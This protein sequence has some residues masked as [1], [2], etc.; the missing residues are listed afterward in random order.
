MEPIEIIRIS[1]ISMIALVNIYFI[2]AHFKQVHQDI[3]RCE[4]VIKA[5]SLTFYKAF[6]KIKDRKKRHAV[7]AVYAFCRYA[8]D[9]ID[10]ANDE[11]GLLQL[12]EDLD[13][14]VK[15]HKAPNYIFRALNHTTK[16]FYAKDYDYNPFYDMIKGQLMDYRFIGYDT[17]EQLLDY[18]YH[19]ASTVGL[20]LV[21][22]LSK[23]HSEQ[24]T[25]F[26]INLGYGMQITN[27]LRD[28]GEDAKKGRIYIPKQEISRANYTIHDLSH[29]KINVEFINMF[30]ALA[31]KAEA[32]FEQAL[33]DINLFPKDV[34]IPLGLS[35]VLYRDILNAC[36]ESE[37]DVF[38]KKN[39]VSEERKNIL[40]KTYIHTFEQGR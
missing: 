3:H 36:R 9:L 21:P 24:L 15:E 28:I 40:I 33:S 6:S 5:N 27:I 35:I 26:A 13:A 38:S 32:Y 31:K 18:C 14:Y 25:D 39:F 34:R 1:L 29:G 4:E 2:Y 8:D 37:Y 16:S 7:Y 20:M 10:E 22:I 23:E 17:Y 12:K 19:V 11:E 30:E